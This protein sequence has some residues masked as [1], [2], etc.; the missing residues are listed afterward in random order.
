MNQE[1]F[2]E[3]IAV[4]AH[5]IMDTLDKEHPAIAAAAVTRLHTTMC[6]RLGFSP[7]TYQEGIIPNLIE[8]YKNNWEKCVK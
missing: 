4:L 8:D 5:K 1:K 3:E 7:E 2:S 6:L